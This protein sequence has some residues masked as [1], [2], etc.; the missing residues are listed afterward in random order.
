M[1]SKFCKITSQLVFVESFLFTLL[2][3]IFLHNQE[4]LS[5]LVECFS[6]DFNQVL[7]FDD[8][9]HFSVK[10]FTFNFENCQFEAFWTFV[11]IFPLDYRAKLSSP[12]FLERFY[13]PNSILTG[14]LKH[15]WTAVNNHVWIIVLEVTWR[16]EC[17]AR[18]VQDNFPIKLVYRRNEGT[19]TLK[20]PLTSLMITF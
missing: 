9:I 1:I 6:W 2:Y 3:L 5:A 8:F 4:K 14:N 16:V 15:F 20:N 13:R 10:N 18:D 11:N 7:T 17:E 12:W 19:A